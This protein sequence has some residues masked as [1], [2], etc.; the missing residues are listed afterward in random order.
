MLQSLVDYR[1][2]SRQSA[3]PLGASAR[4]DWLHHWARVL[5][6]RLAIPVHVAG[7]LPGSGL[8]VCNHLSYLDILAISAAMPAV[9][10]SKAEVRIWP[11]FGKLT[12]IAGTV[13]VDRTRKSGTRKAN[14]GIREALQQG[15]RV[16][17][18]P[19]GTSSGGT[20]VLPFYP[21]LF[22]PA[23]ECGAPITAAHISYSIERGDVGKDIAY[24]GEM[25]FFPHMLKL[26]SKRGMSA[27]VT[28]ADS[29][30]TFSDRKTAASEMRDEV[31]RLHYSSSS[32]TAAELR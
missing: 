25:T 24:W 6:N 14:D 29:A 15:M 21:S 22:E 30:R 2:Q 13:Y 1:R 18:F 9:F 16:V 3:V 23:V 12:D 20:S 11:V 5:L 32:A 4:A 31:L 19:E 10:V 27:T 26:L 8:I 17:I 7:P 28:F